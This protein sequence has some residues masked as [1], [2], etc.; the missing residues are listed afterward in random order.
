MFMAQVASTAFQELSGVLWQTLLSAGDVDAIQHV[1]A[2]YLMQDGMTE[3]HMDV[4]T[5]LTAKMFPQESPAAA[6]VALLMRFTKHADTAVCLI[7]AILWAFPNQFTDHHTVAREVMQLNKQTMQDR[8]HRVDSG[9]VVMLT[10]S[11]ANL[12][13]EAVKANSHARTEMER[14]ELVF[15][16]GVHGD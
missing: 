11:R 3:A 14:L 12:D 5:N 7:P 13:L 1:V 2:M 10:K 9:T 8:L 16:P 6:A 4:P 15:G